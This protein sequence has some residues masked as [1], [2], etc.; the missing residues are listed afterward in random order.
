MDRKEKKAQ[1]DLEDSKGRREMVDKVGLWDHLDSQEI[2]ESVASLD[3]R[4]TRDKKEELDQQDHKDLLA[5]WGK[6]ESG[7]TLGAL[8]H[9][10]QRGILGLKGF[11]ELQALEAFRDRLAAQV[12]PAVQVLLD[13]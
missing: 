5:P 8:D 1:L 10:D 7:E 12:P 3:P 11:Q 6:K 13:Q 2:R 4:V 9:R